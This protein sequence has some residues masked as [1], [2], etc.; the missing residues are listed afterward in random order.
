MQQFFK[1]NKYSNNNRRY[2]KVKLGDVTFI[3]KGKPITEKNIVN[4]PFPV[5]AGGKT[6]P[7]CHNAYTNENIITISASGAYAGYVSYHPNKIWASDCSTVEGVDKK[8]NTLYIYYLL[9]HHQTKIYNL[10]T[11]G[12]QPHVFPKDIYGLKFFISPSIEEQTAIAEVLQAADKEIELL[13]AKAEKLKEQ[14]KGLMQQ[15]LTGKVR[16]KIQ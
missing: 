13:K 2:I 8:S 14:K 5:I 6:S 12:A 9:K 10:Q 4:G 15:L 1:N 7:Y 3:K 16:L 11:G